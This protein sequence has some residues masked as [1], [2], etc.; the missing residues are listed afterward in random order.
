MAR[1][2]FVTCT[3]CKQDIRGDARFCPHC[4]AE[5]HL[6]GSQRGNVLW[7][8]VGAAAASILIFLVLREMTDRLTAPQPASPPVDV[9][10]PPEDM[11][12]HPMLARLEELAKDGDP[13]ALLNLAEAAYQLSHQDPRYLSRAAAPLERF[14]EKYPNHSY[15]LRFLG[16]VNYDLKQPKRAI[17]LYR[18]YL[19]QNPKD[20][21]VLTDLGTQLLFDGQTEAAIDAYQRAIQI[22]P[23]HYHAYRNLNI[24]YLQLGDSDRAEACLKKAREIESVH[25][26]AM[27]PELEQP[28]LP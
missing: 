8:Y 23:N 1:E 26:K 24:A 17:A 6:K 16:N 13:N 3:S 18:R 10:V 25:G 12:D 2:R 7:W 15:A 27:A 4:G 20:A 11:S 14:L 9:S 22:F 28:R 5:L 19:E 21:N